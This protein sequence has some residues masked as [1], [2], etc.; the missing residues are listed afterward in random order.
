MIY[1]AADEDLMKPCEWARWMLRHDFV[2]WDTE[3][4]GLRDDAKI[5][6]IAVVAASG[7]VLYS[8]LINPAVRIP[9]DATAIHGIDNAA[10]RNAPTF[11]EAYPDIRR[12][13]INQRWSVYNLDYDVPRLRYECERW[14]LLF[15]PPR[16]RLMQ[17]VLRTQK[18]F[19]YND[20]WCAME[21]FARHYGEWSS[22]HSSYKWKSLFFA[23][24]EMNLKTT[25]THGALEDA[26]TT[27]ELIKA[28]ALSEDRDYGDEQE[29]Q[30]ND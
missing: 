5:V 28:M 14:G 11:E 10:V 25:P 26:L 2:V 3:T 12:A 21:M 9:K 19:V 23:A 4:T 24:A 20:A 16:R 27:L 13:L 18:S 29:D 7:E 15:P 30:E 6:N 1:V 8:S 22:Y 17:G